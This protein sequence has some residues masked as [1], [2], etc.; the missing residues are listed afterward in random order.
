MAVQRG[1][2]S[3][4]L[5]WVHTAVGVAKAS[6]SMGKTAR[7]SHKVLGVCLEQMAEAT[8]SMLDDEN[9]PWDASS[10]DDEEEYSNVRL[11]TV[12]LYDAALFILQQVKPHLHIWQK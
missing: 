7:F 6:S 9:A 2:L 11:K 8:G 1:R 4:V 12:R 10:S 5:Q 3:L